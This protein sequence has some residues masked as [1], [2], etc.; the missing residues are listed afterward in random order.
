LPCALFVHVNDRADYLT[1]SSCFWSAQVLLEQLGSVSVA[2]ALRA[3]AAA[4]T[5]AE[6]G[7]ISEAEKQLT[8]IMLTLLPTCP[9]SAPLFG[10]LAMQLGQGV[11][12]YLLQQVSGC[13][14]NSP[15]LS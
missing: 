14:P 2:D 1:L 5:E 10:E 7:S 9:L 15:T 3:A 4:P 12:D 8:S 6:S 11:G 13:S